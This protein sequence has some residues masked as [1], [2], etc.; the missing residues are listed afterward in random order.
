MSDRDYAYACGHGTTGQPLTPEQRS[1][2][3]GLCVGIRELSSAEEAWVEVR[4][5]FADQA[6][7][8]WQAPIRASLV[9]PAG[10]IEW[11]CE[12][13]H[14]SFWMTI[15]QRQRYGG[16]KRCWGEAQSSD[17]Q[18]PGI[19]Y[20]RAGLRLPHSATELRLRE[21]LKRYVRI[22]DG[23]N[24]IRVTTRVHGHN[25]VWPDIIIPRLKI[26]IEYDDPGRGGQHHTGEREAADRAKDSAL[27]EV[28]WE[29]I[30]V[31]VGGLGPLGKWDVVAARVTIPVVEA[32]VENMRVIRGDEVLD[33]LT[34][35]VR[36]S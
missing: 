16:C 17:Q 3:C 24:A 32:V 6:A 30:R 21:L 2:P 26:A 34:E 4:E 13:G 10:R 18:G 33:L 11:L 9:P 12:K 15:R 35:L 31:R 7:P 27:R 22:P 1:G 19:A 14:P 23:P 28:G 25:N 36:R 5:Q 20:I 8:A 29:I